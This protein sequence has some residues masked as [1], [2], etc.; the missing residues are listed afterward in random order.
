MFLRFAKLLRLWKNSNEIPAPHPKLRSCNISASTKTLHQ[1]C[2]FGW[3]EKSPSTPLVNPIQ[4]ICQMLIGTMARDVSQFPACSK[5]SRLSLH[6]QSDHP[7][8][9]L[10]LKAPNSFGGMKIMVKNILEILMPL[11]SLLLPKKKKTAKC[12]PSQW[13]KSG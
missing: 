7:R 5:V 13:T 6:M 11:V 2:N 9:H 8:R 4:P 1:K 10:V 12:F 3:S